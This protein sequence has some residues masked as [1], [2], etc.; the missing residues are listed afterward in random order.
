MKF[1][2]QVILVDDV[3][4]AIELAKLGYSIAITTETIHR[5]EQLTITGK[6]L[7]K[8]NVSII[9]HIDHGKTTLSAAIAS[10]LANEYNVKPTVDERFGWRG[11]NK[12]KGKVKHKF[13][14]TLVLGRKHN[15]RSGRRGR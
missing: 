10:E 6:R 9:G 3:D 1:E 11:G 15:K 12:G 5:Y 2:D 14:K 8:V 4:L 7:K 13:Q